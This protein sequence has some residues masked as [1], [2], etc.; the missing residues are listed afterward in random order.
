MKKLIF[1][2]L[3][4][5]SSVFAWIPG[6]CDVGDAK[7]DGFGKA[8]DYKLMKELIEG[9]GQDIPV[10]GYDNRVTWSACFVGALACYFGKDPEKME[11]ASQEELTTAFE[12]AGKLANKC[13]EK[14]K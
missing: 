2:A 11:K 13:Y 3:L 4:C 9:N 14:A 8:Y 10:S 1:I 12:K 7:K 5:T 6:V